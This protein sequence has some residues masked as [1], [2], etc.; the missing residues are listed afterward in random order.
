MSFAR[1]ATFGAILFSD[2]PHPLLCLLAFQDSIYTCIGP[3]DTVPLVAD[4]L[5]TFL[6][7]SSLFFMLDSVYS[8]NFEFTVS[9]LSVCCQVCLLNLLFQILN[10]SILEL[11]FGS[12]RFLLRQGSADYVP[13]AGHLFL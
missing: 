2:F 6:S 12:F 3:S 1:W 5:F 8:S 4:A 9:P 10:S 13:W 7:F 11:P